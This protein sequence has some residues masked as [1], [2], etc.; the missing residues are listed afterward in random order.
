M[1]ASSQATSTNGGDADNER[2]SVRKRAKRLVKRKLGCRVLDIE[3][4]F[5]AYGSLLVHENPT[6][7]CVVG[8]SYLSTIL[9]FF[10]R[11]LFLGWVAW[12]FA[13]EVLLPQDVWR[14]RYNA[15]E[16]ELK[17]GQKFYSKWIV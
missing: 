4:L 6:P 1:Y 15:K 3:L 10:L 13:L 17:D 2:G 11:N 8:A 9:D 14:S 12:E 7:Q 16:Q 5:V